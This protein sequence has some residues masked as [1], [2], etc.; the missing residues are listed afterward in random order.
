[1]KGT[2][3]TTGL[4]ASSVMIQNT[5]T[6]VGLNINGVVSAFSGTGAAFQFTVDGRLVKGDAQ[7]EFFGNSQFTDLANG[8]RVEVKGSQRDAFVY[9]TRLKVN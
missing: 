3:G 1:M 9:A 5:N 4:L 6:D 7:T 8:V 2:T